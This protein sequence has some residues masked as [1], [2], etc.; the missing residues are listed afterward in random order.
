MTRMDFALQTRKKKPSLVAKYLRRL[1]SPG[2]LLVLAAWIVWF[3]LIWYV[4]KAAQD[5]QPFDPFEIL[6]VCSS[7][8]P[9]I[10][11]QTAYVL[12]S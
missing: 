10:T 5:L 7:S 8:S 2:N 9:G 12:V 4:Q 11:W 6:Q 1:R 3:F